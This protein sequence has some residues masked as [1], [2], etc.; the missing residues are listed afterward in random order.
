MADPESRILAFWGSR[1]IQHLAAQSNLAPWS[2]WS[3]WACGTNGLG[4]AL[5]S[6]RP[7]MLRQPEHRCQRFHPWACAVIAV[8][9][10]VTD[11]PLAVLN[12]SRRQRPL[13]DPVLPWLRRVA[14]ATEA[15][16]RQRAHHSGTLLAAAF[17]DA[18]VPPTM[19][20]AVVDPA[21]NVVLANSEAA[22]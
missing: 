7:V 12:I 1:Q 18:R 19:P 5:E 16:L 21:G 9:D 3:E 6:H 11:E 13:P 8:R 14:A 20:L 10:V 22:C 2:T 4:T 15:K 17:A